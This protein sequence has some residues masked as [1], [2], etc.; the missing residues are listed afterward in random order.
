MA[1][2]VEGK[3]VE[4]NEGGR[5]AFDDVL[6]SIGQFGWAQFKVL[7]ISSIFDI[8]MACAILFFLY[9]GYNPGFYCL[10]SQAVERN[11]SVNDIMLMEGQDANGTVTG[12]WAPDVCSINATSCSAIVFKPGYESI[13][14][15]VYYHFYLPSYHENFPYCFC[16]Y[17]S[18]M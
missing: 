16:W 15:E 1:K 12:L 10:S 11:M 5:V 6:D 8:P 2:V 14:T 17:F 9:G 18:L 4:E 3:I 7:L 13:I